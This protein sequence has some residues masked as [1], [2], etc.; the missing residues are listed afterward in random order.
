MG[1]DSGWACKTAIESDSAATII[2]Q[3]ARMGISL[4]MFFMVMDA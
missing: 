3:Q 4:V 1:L 2:A